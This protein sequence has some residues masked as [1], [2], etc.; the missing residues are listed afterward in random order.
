MLEQFLKSSYR[1]NQVE[2]E[3]NP[4]EC[5]RNPDRLF[6]PFQEN[7]AEYGEQNQRDGHLISHPR[8]RER[9]L[10]KVSGGIRRGE[11]HGDDEVGSGKTEQNQNEA[12][13]TP[14]REKVFEHGNAPL[15]IR[16]GLR[17]AAVNRQS[18]GES[19]NNQHKS[20]NRR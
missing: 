19:H 3:I 4:D 18:A 6:E 12:L 17:D 11:R 5:Y 9:V 10:R 13:P 15:A 7:C 16:A 8:R 2:K 20:G 14:T 1:D